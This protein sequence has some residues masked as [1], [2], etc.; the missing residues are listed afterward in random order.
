MRHSSAALSGERRHSCS[1]GAFELEILMQRTGW[2][3][4]DPWRR[5]AGSS[6]MTLDGAGRVSSHQP[7]SHTS[8]RPRHRGVV[9]VGPHAGM[10]RG[11]ACWLRARPLPHCPQGTTAILVLL[12]CQ[13]RRGRQDG[14][15]GRWVPHVR[16]TPTPTNSAT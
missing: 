12:S 6:E 14:A 2:S 16:V 5:R 3:I 13:E 8:E 7:G 4:F 11:E 10:S 9:C 15:R 1:Q